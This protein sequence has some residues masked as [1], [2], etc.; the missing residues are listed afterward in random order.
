MTDL[1]EYFSHFPSHCACESWTRRWRADVIRFNWYTLCR[2]QQRK[3]G[4]AASPPHPPKKKWMCK[5]HKA[6][7]AYCLFTYAY[8]AVHEKKYIYTCIQRL[9]RQG[10]F[11]SALLA[12]L[13]LD[14][15]WNAHQPLKSRSWHLKRRSLC[16]LL[17]WL[18]A[19]QIISHSF[20]FLFLLVNRLH[21]K[22]WKNVENI[23]GNS[24]WCSRGHDRAS[25]AEY[26]NPVGGYSNQ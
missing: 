20:A 15:V 3:K 26:F 22:T 12:R 25:W 18:S 1:S 8:T 10:P 4:D 23:I 5:R 2:Q 19:N 14:N 24:S 7:F 9:E 6:A 11:W 17:H 21:R 13:H 16:F